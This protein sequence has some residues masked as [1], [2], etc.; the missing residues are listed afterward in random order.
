VLRLY[1]LHAGKAFEDIAHFLRRG[2]NLSRR[3]VTD[4]GDLQRGFRFN[5]LQSMLLVKFSVIVKHTVEE[6]D[7]QIHNIRPASGYTC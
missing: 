4:R 7:L 6:I 2:G 3:R 5:V 1:P